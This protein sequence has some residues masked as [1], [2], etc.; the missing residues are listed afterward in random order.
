M[1]TL[2]ERFAAYSLNS[3][4]DLANG[5]LVGTFGALSDAHE[6]GK[7]YE[8]Y[9]IHD[10]KA[11]ELFVKLGRSVDSNGFQK[12]RRQSEGAAVLLPMRYRK[13]GCRYEMGRAD[14][15]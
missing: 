15:V 6:A 5:T 12:S 14:D 13:A 11:H 4:G 9:A 8:A 2:N 10:R 7:A 1:N 3:D